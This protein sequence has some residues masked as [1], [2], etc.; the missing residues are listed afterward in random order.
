M[1]EVIRQI[2]LLIS[3]DVRV[4]TSVPFAL[5][6]CGG[7]ALTWYHSLYWLWLVCPVV[8]VWIAIVLILPYALAGLN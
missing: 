7:L 5:V 2:M 1:W 8:V 3:E 6:T 4:W